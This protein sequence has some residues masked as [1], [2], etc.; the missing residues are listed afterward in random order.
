MGLRGPKPKGKVKIR[1]SPNFAY[2]IGLLA[3]DGC[4]SS[5]GRHILFVSKD[6]EQ[7]RNYMKA[8]GIVNAIGSSRS[9][10][11]GQPVPRVQFGDTLF[12]HFLVGIGLTP[13]KSRTI[14]EL[15][16]PR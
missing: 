1:W 12:Y 3:T 8:L 6:D 9:S 11:T 10:F 15:K 14:G 13:A 5:S 2:A 16:I 4:L 7:I